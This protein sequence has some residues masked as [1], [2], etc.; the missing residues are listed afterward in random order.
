[1]C[2]FIFRLEILADAGD[3]D[4]P[5]DHTLNTTVPGQL[6]TKPS[7]HL[8]FTDVAPRPSS[9]RRC[10]HKKTWC[11]GTSLYCCPLGA[12]WC[13]HLEQVVQPVKPPRT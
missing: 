9:G 12:V 4:W 7:L 11:V 10:C 8:R 13:V 1:M 2:S 3:L 6:V 5:T